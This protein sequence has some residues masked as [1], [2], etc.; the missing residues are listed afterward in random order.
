MAP[1]SAH[2]RVILGIASLLCFFARAAWRVPRVNS[3][4]AELDPWLKANASVAFITAVFG[5]YEKSAKPWRK[6]SIP[7]DFICFTNNPHLI[8][9]G[10]QLDYT[11]YHELYPSPL[12]DGKMINTFHNKSHPAHPFL[13]AKYYKQVSLHN[14]KED[15]IPNLSDIRSID[16][17]LHLL[18]GF[19]AFQNIPRLRQYEIVV[20]VDGTIEVEF[21][22]ASQW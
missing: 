8:S 3:T 11:P 15:L 13:I 19:Q 4:E 10:W 20:W 21:V 6:Q 12:D 18:H 2:L 16:I 14:E 9:N 7:T 17:D 5:T 1:R 22:N